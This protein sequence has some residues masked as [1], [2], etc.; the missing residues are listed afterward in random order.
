MEGAKEG[1]V[2][3]Y[4]VVLP[5]QFPFVA[6]V[7]L[8]LQLPLLH[9][10]PAS[11]SIWLI[12]MVSGYPMGTLTASEMYQKGK[13]TR[14]SLTPLAAYANMAGPLFVIGTV[15]SLLQ[16]TVLGYWLLLTHWVSAGTLF[17]F[18]AWRMKRNDMAAGRLSKE[19]Q[20]ALPL[21]PLGQLLGNAVGDTAELMLK[22]CGFITLFSVLQ[23]WLPGW[24]GALLEM[25]NG[26]RW[27]T[28]SKLGLTEKLVLCSFLLGFSGF[29]IILQSFAAA[30]APLDT[31]QYIICKCKQGVLG[32]ALMW[33][34][35]QFFRM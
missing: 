21:S 17:W 10:A 31:K 26:I 3:W 35:C 19:G 6:A 33:G 16:S 12:G 15:G 18:S 24:I 30:K 1:M 14:E 7:K 11:W 4:R 22:V 25:T 8:L 20:V 23:Q 13:M 9:Q 29:C 27:L 32:A 28:E 2:L 34:I 5:S